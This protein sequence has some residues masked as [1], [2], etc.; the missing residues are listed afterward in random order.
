MTEPK[1]AEQ[2][3]CTRIHRDQKRCPECGTIQNGDY[4]TRSPAVT[5]TISAE[6]ADFLTRA[7]ETRSQYRAHHIERIAVIDLSNLAIGQVIAFERT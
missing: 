7:L 2:Y 1:P 6:W 5:V 4:L 3:Q